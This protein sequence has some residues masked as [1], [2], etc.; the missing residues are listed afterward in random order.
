M[1]SDVLC[2]NHSVVSSSGPTEYG[3]VDSY[4]L[5]SGHINGYALAGGCFFLAVGAVC[6]CMTHER[7]CI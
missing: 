4:F 3:D 5:A 2:R 6:V 1:C 7:Q